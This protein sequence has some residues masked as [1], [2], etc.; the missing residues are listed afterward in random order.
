MKF[1]TR[2]DIDLPIDQVFAQVSD[3]DQFERAALRRGV[4]IRRMD[5]SAQPK[6]GMAWE[7]DFFAARQ[8]APSGCATD[9]I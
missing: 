4:K 5:D 1:S 3:L 2:E 8:G 6:V 9:R 7:M